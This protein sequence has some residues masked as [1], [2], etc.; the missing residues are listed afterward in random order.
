MALEDKLTRLDL[1]ALVLEPARILLPTGST[2]TAGAIVLRDFTADEALAFARQVT[3]PPAGQSAEAQPLWIADCIAALAVEP[4]TARRQL[5][6]VMLLQI[7]ELA[8][9]VQTMDPPSYTVTAPPALAEVTLHGRVRGLYPLRLATF[10]LA[11][12]LREAA[13]AQDQAEA[14]VDELRQLGAELLASALTDTTIEEILALP[15]RTRMAL[16]A[17]LQESMAE[18][19]RELQASPLSGAPGPERG[20][21]KKQ[22]AVSPTRSRKSR[23]ATAGAMLK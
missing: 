20:S 2:G 17:L 14:Q 23:A 18:A 5:D 12:R 8:R 3:Q 7:F 6:Q 16:D 15:Q 13:E 10:A 4:E 19:L 22:G 11:L 9:W 1:D 21:R